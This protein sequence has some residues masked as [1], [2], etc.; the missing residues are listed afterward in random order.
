[1]RYIR[2]VFLLMALLLV[3][4][5]ASMNAF[6]IQLHYFFGQVKIYFPVLLFLIFLIGLLVGLLFF[7]SSYIR[8]ELLYRKQAVKIRKMQIELDNLRAIPVKDELW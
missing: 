7:L 1:M 6:F 4:L 8:K 5:F 3:I 2:F